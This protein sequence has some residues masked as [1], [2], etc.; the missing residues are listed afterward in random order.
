MPTGVKGHRSPKLSINDNML[1][2]LGICHPSELHRTVY[3]VYPDSVQES[4]VVIPSPFKGKRSLP[5]DL[6]RP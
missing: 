5:D 2:A 1:V 6:S 3:V 4:Q